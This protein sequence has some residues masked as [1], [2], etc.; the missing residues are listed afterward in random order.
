MLSGIFID[1]YLLKKCTYKHDSNFCGIRISISTSSQ[2]MTSRIFFWKKSPGV[3]NEKSPYFSSGFRPKIINFW[4]ST[5]LYNTPK[6]YQK[7]F[8]QTPSLCP[9]AVPSY[10]LSQR[11]PK[12]W[13]LFLEAVL[14]VWRAGW[15]RGGDLVSPSSH[16][17]E[18]QK[19]LPVPG[20]LARTLLW[21]MG[22]SPDA[23]SKGRPPETTCL[24]SRATTCRSRDY[25][26]PVQIPGTSFTYWRR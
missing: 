15:F 23:G 8:C 4:G 12:A 19:W 5:T 17:T 13:T 20:S 9:N 21:S 10:F 1:T 2:N 3:Q 16:T 7:E 18:W 25:S 24:P 6:R 26:P 11:V 22:T 14:A